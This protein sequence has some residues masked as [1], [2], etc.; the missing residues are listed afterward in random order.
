MLLK[1]LK[2]ILWYWDRMFS[3][4]D[5]IQLKHWHR[6]HQFVEAKQ[7]EQ[8]VDNNP[9]TFHSEHSLLDW[10]IDPRVPVVN[11]VHSDRES[12]PLRSLHPRR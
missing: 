7:N 10:G 8:S 6:L 12:D 4:L 9:G 5:D 11:K 2:I 1:I 3:K